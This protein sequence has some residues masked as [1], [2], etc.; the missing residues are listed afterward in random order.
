MGD[1]PPASTQC[2][3]CG[4]QEEPGEEPFKTCSKC[5][6]DGCIPAAKFCSGDCLKQNWPRHRRWHADQA[7]EKA[8]AVEAEAAKKVAAEAAA[9]KAAER[10]AE[11]E[12]Q[13]LAAQEARRR[14]S[15]E[16]A[17]NGGLPHI[18]LDVLKEKEP[19]VKDLTVEATT[20]KPP[21]LDE[22]SREHMMLI[23]T[24]ASPPAPPAPAYCIPDLAGAGEV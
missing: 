21:P 23:L 19:F 17:P 6:A 3:G 11:A 7:A 9:K 5:R 13:A 14:A 24:A 10:Q 2:W 22:I 18:P 12:K 8:R 1:D 20:D 16:A 15:A 4:R